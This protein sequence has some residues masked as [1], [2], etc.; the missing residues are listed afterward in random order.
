MS[1]ENVATVRAVFEAVNRGEFDQA[2]EQLPEEFVADWSSSDRPESGV[3][4]GREEIKKVF[5]F[6]ME[7]WSEWDWFESEIIAVGDVV[8]RVGG[9]RARG[10]G[11]GLEVVARG[12][13]VW[14]FREG[15]AVS[16]KVS[17]KQSRGPRSHRAG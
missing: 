5:E 2:L 7:P 15:I 11:S 1:K 10:E 4:R 9:L 14:T 3:F 8:I 6:A 17:P 16:V 12:A 13:Q